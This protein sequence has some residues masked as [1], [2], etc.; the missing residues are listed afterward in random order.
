[1]SICGS[2]GPSDDTAPHDRESPRPIVLI[3]IG[4]V[5]LEGGAFGP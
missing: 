1:M 4:L 3:T 5:I 2:L